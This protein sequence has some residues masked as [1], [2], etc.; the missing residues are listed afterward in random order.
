MKIL[1]WIKALGADGFENSRTLCLGRPAIILPGVL[2]AAFLFILIKPVGSYA[3]DDLELI[4]VATAENEDAAKV[5][6][7]IAEGANVN[8]K[9]FFGITAL[10]HASRKGHIEIVK[11]LLDKGA[12]VNAKDNDGNTAL[13]E[14][15]RKGYIEIVQFLK[16]AGAKE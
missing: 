7:L 16:K 12:D 3:T 15:S 10:I 6:S 9:G 11:I 2:V 14:A 13:T 1:R 8:T 4:R 5:R